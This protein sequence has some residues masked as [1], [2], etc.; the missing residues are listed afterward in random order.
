MPRL[1]VVYSG[2]MDSFTLINHAIKEGHEVSA[3]SFD[4]GQRHKKELEFALNFCSS[5]GLNHKLIDISNI[6]TLL[7]GSSL[8]D[9]LEVP[10]GHYEEEAMKNTVVPNRNMI[11]ISLSI[12]Y[13]IST[14]SR[15]VWYG[16]HY[17]DHSI[18]PDCRPAFV[19]AMN[20]V[21]LLADYEPVSVKA[22]FINLS[23]GK[24]LSKGIEMGLDYS[25]SWTCY[26]GEDKACGKCGACVERLEAFEENGQR[27]PIKYL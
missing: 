8:T 2:G 1:I 19:E 25:Q 10:E 3:V 27:D 16:A 22:P 11:M 15:E 17:G 9:N 20:S 4:Y 26:K 24:I 13:A 6:R 18:Y 23:K 7:K 21:A 12:A 14:G 5:K